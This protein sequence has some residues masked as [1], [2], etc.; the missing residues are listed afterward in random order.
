MNAADTLAAAI[1]RDLGAPS[2]AVR[3]FALYRIAEA[4]ADAAKYADL[5]RIAATYAADPCALPEQVAERI[6]EADR[7]GTRAYGLAVAAAE[8]ATASH[9]SGS[10]CEVREALYGAHLADLAAVAARTADDARYGAAGGRMPRTLGVHSRHFAASAEAVALA[11]GA[12][13]LART[14]A[15][16]GTWRERIRLGDLAE[17][18][19]AEAATATAEATAEDA[20]M[21]WAP[22]SPIRGIAFTATRDAAAA[23]ADAEAA[24]AASR[25]VSREVAAM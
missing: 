3:A 14:A 10:A 13:R 12:L 9:T 17:R 21:E 16:A 5:A 22:T 6:A 8:W 20:R 2:P 1:R 15:E 19:I 24:L 25:R 11:L 23:V 7:L 4:V 18:A